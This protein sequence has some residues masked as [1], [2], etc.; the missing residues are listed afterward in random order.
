MEGLRGFAVFLVFLVHYFTLA[1]PWIAR[2]SPSDIVGSSLRV[3]GNAG[4]DLFFVLSGYLIYGTLLAKPKKFWSFMQRRIRRIYPAFAAVFLVYVSLSLFLGKESKIPPGAV[5]GSVY[6]LQNFLLLPGLIKIEPLITVAWSL[7]YEMFYYLS[8][9][10]LIAI[11]GLRQR[12]VQYR[13][14]LV[15]AAV[16]AAALYCAFNGG[17]IRLIMFGAGILLHELIAGVPGNNA[18]R[19]S[20]ALAV[21]VAGLLVTLVPTSGPEG[22]SIKIAVLFATF[23]LLCH[24]CFTRPTDWL[25]R[26]FSWTPLRWLGNMSYSYYLIHGL[27][28][29]ALFMALS[30]IVIPAPSAVLVWAFLPVAFGFTAVA[31]GALFLAIERPYSLSKEVRG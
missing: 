9:P 17:H 2:G 3:V 24:S 25:S 26:M 29:K 14:A 28:L 18:L 13:I 15:G 4:V 12:S 23:L 20:T 27:M 21:L 1:T 31:G 7:S 22:Y 6:L 30:V 8:I 10:L 5:D 19:S 11:F 16:V